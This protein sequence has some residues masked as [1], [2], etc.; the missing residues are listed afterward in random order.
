MLKTILVIIHF[1]CFYYRKMVTTKTLLILKGNYNFLCAEIVKLA[2]SAYA[3][4]AHHNRPL[5]N[6]FPMGRGMQ[7]TLSH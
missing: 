4:A 1:S 3:M 5:K 2:M 7:K 6:S